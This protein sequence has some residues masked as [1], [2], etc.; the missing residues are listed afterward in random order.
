MSAMRRSSWL[1][2]SYKTPTEPTR[3]RMA[4]WRRLKALG[5]V[6]LQNGVCLLPSNVDHLRQIKMLAHEITEMKGE[7]V[8]LE[9]AP[10]DPA[11][12]DYVIAR[13]R[14]DRD[15]AFREFIE[16]C[17]GFDEEIT[18]EIAAGKLTYAELEENDEDLKKLRTW[19][20]KITV[21]DFYGAS[22]AA[23]ARSRLERCESRL[24]SFSH[25]VFKAH[26]A[27]AGRSGDG[28]V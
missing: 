23:E 22:L 18:R 19:F 7:A 5:A 27:Q 12:E 28:G 24:E 8:L 4:V 26:Q 25:E 13:F 6:Y 11:Q 3:H 17:D 14:S 21:L 1:L 20:G 9:A 15:D 10:L 2:L 16:R